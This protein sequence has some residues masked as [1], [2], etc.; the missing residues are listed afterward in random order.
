MKK[1]SQFLVV[2]LMLDAAWV[3]YGQLT[4]K[5]MWPYI[6]LYWI[7]LTAK[8]LVDLIGGTIA[9]NLRKKVLGGMKDD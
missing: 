7:I 3:A 4:N 1:L 8:N 5:F 2:L 6:C 9:K